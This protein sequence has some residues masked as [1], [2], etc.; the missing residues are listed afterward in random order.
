MKKLVVMV[1]LMAICINLPACGKKKGYSLDEK[2]FF[3]VMTNLQYYPEQYLDKD[4]E[5]DCFSYALE[6]IDGKTYMCG[7]RKCS[8][9]YGCTCG[10][11]TVIGLLLEYDG[12]IPEPRNQG[13]DTNDKTWMHLKGK[14]KDNEKTKIRIYAYN[15]NEIDYDTIETIEF[16][17]FKVET[18]E[19]IED[20]SNLHYY[21]S[22]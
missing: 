3:L 8:S 17:S 5:F 16:L 21:V 11:D 6:D 2:T 12:K 14:L 20:Y 9:G 22:K 18:L 15:N 1:L 10:K 7:V 13:D 19:L 4:I